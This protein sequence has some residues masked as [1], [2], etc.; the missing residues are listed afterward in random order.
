MG[1]NQLLSVRE[2]LEADSKE[3][4]RLVKMAN[5]AKRDLAI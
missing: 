3:I 2:V 5:E 4:A 1:A